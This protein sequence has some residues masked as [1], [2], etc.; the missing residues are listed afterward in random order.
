[1]TT[2]SLHVTNIEVEEMQL[3]Y[4]NPKH[5]H[6][7]HISGEFSLISNPS[8]PSELNIVKDSFRDHIF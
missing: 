6:S 4:L 7:S 5:Y 8:L 1:M 3:F 2:F